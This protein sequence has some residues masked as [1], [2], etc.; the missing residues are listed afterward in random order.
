MELKNSQTQTQTQTELQT[1]EKYKDRI[2]EA[3]IGAVK[4]VGGCVLF[5]RDVYY[6]LK[7]VFDDE[8]TF[9]KVEGALWSAID[10]LKL[11]EITLYKIYSDPEESFHDVVVATFGRELTDKQLYVLREVASLF[12]VDFYDRYNEGEGQFFESMPIY[13]EHRWEVYVT[14]HNLVKM[15]TGCGGEDE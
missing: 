15:W 14:L 7:E 11:S 10:G 3:I 4:S 12:G 6:E 2:R 13:D 1:I 5:Y 8:E 9:E